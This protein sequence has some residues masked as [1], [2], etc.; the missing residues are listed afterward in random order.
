MESRGRQPEAQKWR[1]SHDPIHGQC[2]AWRTARGTPSAIKTHASQP[3]DLYLPCYPLI[4]TNAYCSLFFQLLSFPTIDFC[5]C[6][7]QYCRSLAPN[8]LHD[9]FIFRPEPST[10]SSYPLHFGHFGVSL[11]ALFTLR[12]R[13]RYTMA[14][15]I[16]SHDTVPSGPSSGGP[17]FP[18]PLRRSTALS[19]S[20]GRTQISV[21]ISAPTNFTCPDCK[22]H[23]TGMRSF[24]FSRQGSSR[25]VIKCARASCPYVALEIG[26]PLSPTGSGRRPAYP[27]G[28]NHAES[29]AAAT[30]RLNASTS[31]FKPHVSSALASA[32]HVAR[33]FGQADLETIESASPSRAGEDSEDKIEAALAETKPP[34]THGQRSHEHLVIPSTNI[35]TSIGRTAQSRI[36]TRQQ[37]R[38][39]L[40]QRISLLLNSRVVPQATRHIARNA[41][42]GFANWALRVDGVSEDPKGKQR[43]DDGIAERDMLHQATLSMSTIKPMTSSYTH[44]CDCSGSCHCFTDASEIQ[45]NRISPMLQHDLDHK[46]LQ[47]H[48]PASVRSLLSDRLPPTKNIEDFYGLSPPNPHFKRQSTGSNGSSTV[49]Y[50]S[51]MSMSMDS[52]TPDL[53][54]THPHEVNETGHMERRPEYDDD[55]AIQM[56]NARLSHEVQE[57]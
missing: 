54:L 24:R 19:S 38:Q 15:Q 50:S 34:T 27:N 2:T 55:S 10:T 5:R 21:T 20:S 7:S 31:E 17:P 18:G 6:K 16:P 30:R 45:R 4:I 44:R 51:E 25:N 8:L 56:T 47:A 23:N 12:P 11:V 9:V 14:S 42:Q 36:S 28:L 40:R 46:P 39:V 49:R 37:K 41:I 35:P 32:T 48:A 33:S 13:L 53:T 52:S 43:A 26:G 57:G 3:F 29:S 22:H 1:S